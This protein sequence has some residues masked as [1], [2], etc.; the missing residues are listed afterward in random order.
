MKTRLAK[1][2]GQ[3][4][5]T[6]AWVAPAYAGRQG[7]EWF[8]TPRGAQIKPHQ[9]AFLDSAHPL[10][11]S[12]AGETIHGYRWGTGTR[13]VLFVHGW[14]SHSFRWKNYIQA[15]AGDEYTLYALDAP[16]HGRS[17]GRILHVPK[18]AEVINAFLNEVGEVDA[19][20]GHSLG[21]FAALYAL[22]QNPTLPVR[23]LV[24]T[25]TPG[26]V[27][28]FMHHYR[29]TLGLS[30]RALQRIYQHFI[31]VV[32]HHPRFYSAA[33]FAESLWLPG[34]IIH[35]KGDL[36]A[37][38]RHAQAIQKNWSH[39]QLITTRGLG[40]NLKSAEVI[41]HVV[42]FIGRDTQR[43]AMIDL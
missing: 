2:I 30:R 14:Q 8:C 13:K 40:H 41:A 37:P 10:T 28:E 20:V 17:E 1:V 33:R 31:G 3:W 24:I 29:T 36:D 12:V 7:F 43:T 19:I 25:G 26:E 32:G 38:Y 39:A 22:F 6:L 16:A 4:L 15:M 21:S 9:R 27:E 34:L 23:K 18:Y 42:R 11:L 35:D 5:N